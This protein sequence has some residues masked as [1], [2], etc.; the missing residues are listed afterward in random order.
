MEENSEPQIEQNVQTKAGRDGDR[1]VT[2]SCP[3]VCLPY[4]AAGPANVISNLVDKSGGN[5]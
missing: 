3:P 4:I 2:P 1:R 5:S